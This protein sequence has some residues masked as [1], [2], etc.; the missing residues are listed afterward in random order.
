MKPDILRELT[1]KTRAVVRATTTWMVHLARRGSNR[2]LS[3]M[4][5][6]DGITFAVCP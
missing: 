5:T 4:V 1:R 2:P 3:C 6:F